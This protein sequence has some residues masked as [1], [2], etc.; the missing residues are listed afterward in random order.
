MKDGRRHV[1]SST[2]RPLRAPSIGFYYH[3]ETVPYIAAA[4]GKGRQKRDDSDFSIESLRQIEK[5]SRF[6][7]NAHYVTEPTK[8]KG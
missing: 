3:F 6:R 7:S 2:T 8:A 1:V 5:R 4:F